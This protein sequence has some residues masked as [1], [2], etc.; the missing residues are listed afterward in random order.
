MQEIHIYVSGLVQGVGF[1]AIVKRHA[2]LYNIK[3]FVRNLGDGRVEICAQGK[4]EQINNFIHMIQSRPGNGA[5]E[6]IETKYRPMQE[7][8]ET[9]EVR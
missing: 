3:G 9:F 7:A 5:V 2:V 6:G 1:R 8:F 4:G